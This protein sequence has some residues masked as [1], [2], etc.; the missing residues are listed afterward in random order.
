MNYAAQHTTGCTDRKGASDRNS[1]IAWRWLAATALVCLVANTAQAFPSAHV[2]PGRQ[3]PWTNCATSGCHGE[4]LLGG[5]SGVAC[6][7]CHNPF[8]EPDLPPTGH[9]RPGRDDPMNNCTGCHGE[10]PT[11]PETGFCYECHGD[12]WS[13]GENQPPVADP[14]TGYSGTVGV[15]LTFDGSGSS[16]PDGDIVAYD[17]DFDDGSTGIGVNPTHTYTAAGTYTVTLTVTDDGGATDTQTTTATITEEGGNSPPIVDPG[18]PYFA[19]PGEPVTFDASGTVDPDGDTLIY[20]WANLGDGTQP[21]FPSFSPTFTKEDGYAEV[22]TY[23]GIL[24]VSDGVKTVTAE[25]TV[26]ISDEANLPPTADAGGPYEGTVGTAVQFDGSGSSDPDGDA[27]T[28]NWTF[29]D[30]ASGTGVSPSH[31][32]AA[33]GTY[34]ATLT[35]SD[36]IND[37]VTST[38]TVTITEDT[39][40]PPADADW[41]IRLPLVPDGGTLNFDE[42]AG[43]L[44]V[45]AN[46]QGAGTVFGIGFDV[47]PFTVWMDA[48][49]ALFLGTKRGGD[50]MGMVFSFNGASDTIWFAEPLNAAAAQED[51]LGIL[52]AMM[53]LLR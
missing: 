41:E 6:V 23:T 26:T 51:P 35:V 14:G 9:H 3:N 37:P 28:Y 46:Y 36:G 24:G 30:G 53:G 12:L 42:F 50:M 29:G 32:Y 18:G 31:A 20:L 47:A 48:K 19:R 33:A 27:L 39:I 25:F 17:W 21:P 38:A 43:V 10:D 52:G 4:D 44:F 49:G 8:S 22:G 1:R 5:A 13:G 2:D 11:D 7:D 40:P 15:A 16:D 45:E 34:T